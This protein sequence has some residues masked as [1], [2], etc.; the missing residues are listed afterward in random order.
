MTDGKQLA[1]ILVVKGR[2]EEMVHKSLDHV[3]AAQ[4]EVSEAEEAL[5]LARGRE[6]NAQGQRMAMLAAV[7]AVA[8]FEDK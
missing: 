2:L 4:A 8:R 6:K 1:G 5:L 3:N 7:Q